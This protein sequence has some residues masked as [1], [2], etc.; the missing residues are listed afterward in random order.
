M[1]YSKAA[2]RGHA[3]HPML[4]AFPVAFYTATLAAF[5]VYAATAGVFWFQ[6]AVVTNWAGVGFAILAAVPGL[7]DWTAGIPKNTPAKRR[8]RQHLVLNLAAFV[9]FLISALIA[10]ARLGVVEP[11]AAWNIVLSAIGLGFTIPAGVLGW[12][13]VQKNHV[14]IELTPEQIRLEPKREPPGEPIGHRA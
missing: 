2:I 4:V 11:G 8:G 5:I 3:I 1:Y 12:E 9:A 10:T 6:F 14:G 7:I 13:L